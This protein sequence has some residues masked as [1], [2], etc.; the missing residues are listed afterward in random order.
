[1]I[2]YVPVNTSDLSDISYDELFFTVANKWK[3]IISYVFV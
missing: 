1:M 2:F 3:V